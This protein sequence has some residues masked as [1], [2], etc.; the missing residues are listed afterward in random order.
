M[1]YNNEKTSG[2][3]TPHDQLVKKVLENPVAA[4]ELMEEYLP[5]SF[6][7]LVDLSTIKVEKESFVE[8]H[9]TKRLSDLVLSVKTKDDEKA[10]VYTILEHQS[11]SDYFISFRLLKY[12]LLLLE[13]HIDKQAKNKLPLICPLVIYHG[14]RKYQAPRNFWQLFN[15]PELAMEFIAGNY[16][17]LD[18]NSMQDNQIN[19]EKHLSII[20]Y[21]LKHVHQRDK[22]KL[23]EDIFK[24]CQP[25]IL[26]DKNQDYIYTKM[27]LWYFD[28]K[29]PADK[30]QEVRKIILD[31]LP[32]EKDGENIMKSIADTYIEEGEA[33]GEARGQAIGEKRG[34]AK[35]IEQTAI[36]ML[37]QKADIKFISSVTG[38]STELLLK[39]KSRT[40]N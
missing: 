29:I 26:I 17:L 33:R 32:S 13:R 38:L 22:L 28:S 37:K 15:H 8:E 14:A 12:S 5:A 16:N 24:N 3:N 39:L 20:L 30:K 18:L 23:I 21:M 11:S 6:K 31:N 4:R 25:A 35:G 1:T 7:Q 36:N 9:L 34:K 27:I 19:Y 2:T 40:H 10:F